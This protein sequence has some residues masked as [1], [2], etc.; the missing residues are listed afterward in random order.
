MNSSLSGC[1]YS[2]NQQL[3]QGF[4]LNLPQK[5]IKNTVN[6]ILVPTYTEKL[7]KKTFY[8]DTNIMFARVF[9]SPICA[10]VSAS[11]IC[12]YLQSQSH[13]TVALLIGYRR[14]INYLD[15]HM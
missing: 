12:M 13:I 14:T 8:T 15:H 11:K 6:A 7:K 5:I 2:T 9:Q 3:L 10:C 4:S 1:M